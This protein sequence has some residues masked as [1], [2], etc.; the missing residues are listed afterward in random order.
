M[1][2]CDQMCEPLP[3]LYNGNVKPISCHGS[4][5]K[6]GSVCEFKCGNSLL[7]V[8]SVQRT[9][10]QGIWTGVDSRCISMCSCV[11]NAPKQK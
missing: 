9:C 6:E 11:Q 7:L 3:P 8:G 10:K 5:N 2:S 4:N 1:P